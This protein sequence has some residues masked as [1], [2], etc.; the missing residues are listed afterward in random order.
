M[1]TTLTSF[2]QLFCL[3]KRSQ[4]KQRKMTSSTLTQPKTITITSHQTQSKQDPKHPT[5]I[6]KGKP[7]SLKQL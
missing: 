4:E 5:T 2:Y 1:E 3:K 7:I 6:A